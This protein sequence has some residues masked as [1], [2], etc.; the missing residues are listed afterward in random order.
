M[1]SGWI[2][3]HLIKKTLKQP[4][5]LVIP[6]VFVFCPISFMIRTPEW[7]P[8]SS[9]L[10]FLHP[11]MGSSHCCSVD[12]RQLFVTLK[13]ELTVVCSLYLQPA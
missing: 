7:D 5:R 11:D 10:G 13:V 2:I 4:T 12:I 9:T 6:D 8:A 1:R 3:F